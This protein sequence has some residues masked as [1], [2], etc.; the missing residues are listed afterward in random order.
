[1]GTRTNGRA[2]AAWILLACGTLAGC[3]ADEARPEAPPEERGGLVEAEAQA[4]AEPEAPGAA[5]AEAPAEPD[6]PAARAERP[7]APVLAIDTH[8]DTTQRMLAGDDIGARMPDGHLDLPRMREGGLSGAFFSIWVS[9][10]RYPGE[11]AWE[12]AL[13]LIGAVRRLAERH[14]EAAALCTSAEEVRAAHA[15]GRTAL[16]MG[17]EGGHA[18]GAAEDEAVVLERLRELHRL[19]VRY[20]TI[21]WSNDNA[22]GHASTGDHP[23]RGLTALGRRVV[24]E[25]NRLGMI[26]DVSHVSDRTFWDILEVTE[27]PVLASHSSSRALA[28]HPRN[29]TDA[30][31]RAVGEGGGA[32]CVNFYTQ[33]IDAEYRA[34]RR[35][36]EREHRAEL[37]ALRE[38][39]EHSWQR[40]ADVN[41]RVRELAPE[42]EVPTVRTLGAHFARV[43]EVAGPEAACLGSDF[44][45]VGELPVG[46]EDASRLGALRAELERRDL[47]VRPIFG[48][49]V[50]RVLAAQG[51]TTGE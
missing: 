19:G 45:G 26:V 9:P 31:I 50:L 37:R 6:P 49:N 38:A 18:L 23:E 1:V 12:R 32:V 42:L 16:L 29:M 43:V 27:R 40:W 28:D 46:L 30:M 5:R 33:Y 36:V 34:A 14:P 24:R 25:M 47:P 13:A 48:A 4:E 11:A 21:T 22:L 2:R 8:V 7:A 39:H 44:D 41:R 20:L 17:V 3:G 51:G 35:A 10:S 15:A